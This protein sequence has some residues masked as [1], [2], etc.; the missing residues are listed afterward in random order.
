MS[1]DKLILKEGMKIE[2]LE[3]KYG[4]KKGTHTIVRCYEP[5]GFSLDSG[6][7]M[8]QEWVDKMKIREVKD[9]EDAPKDTHEEVAEVKEDFKTEKDLILKEGMEIE[10][11]ENDLSW[12][13][14]IP[15]GIYA[16]GMEMDISGEFY[17]EEG[18]YIHQDWVKDLLI[19]EVK[20]GEGIT[21]SENRLEEDEDDTTPPSDIVEKSIEDNEVKCNCTKENTLYDGEMEFNKEFQLL[22][23]KFCKTKEGKGRVMD[24][25]FYVLIKK[26]LLENNFTYT[27]SI[28]Y[29]LD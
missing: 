22:I 9:S 28:R 6:L 15:E 1:E 17:L 13:K 10:I 4:I 12:D 19:R 21:H 2:V 7:S 26:G 29:E 18:I 20:Y 11:K 3:D 5:G 27:N 25:I 23:D 8:P 24:A 16:V 14:F